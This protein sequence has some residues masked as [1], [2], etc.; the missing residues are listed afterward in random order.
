MDEREYFLGLDLGTASV[1]WAVTDP[2]YRLLRAKGKDMWGVRLCEEADAPE[3]R[4][5]F[6][7]ARRKRNREVLRILELKLLFSEEIEKT[8]PGFF[9]RLEESMLWEEDRSEGNRQPFSLFCDESVPAE[10]EGKN[11]GK[12]YTD[13]DYYKEYPTIFHLRKKLAGGE[14]P[15]DARFLYLALLHMFKHRGHYL[16]SEYT[17]TLSQVLKGHSYVCEAKVASYEKHREDLKKLKRVVRSCGREAYDEMFREMKDGISN[18]SAYIRSVNSDESKSR[19]N[20]LNGKM[21]MESRSKS[22]F[23]KYVAKVISSKKQDPEAQEILKEIKK[24]TFLPKQM[25]AENA[26]IPNH[27][28]AR[29]MKAILENAAK[30]FPFLNETDEAGRTVSERILRLFTFHIPYYVGPLGEEYS[31]KKGYHVWAKRKEKGKIYPWNF[32]EKIDMQETAERYVKRMIRKCSYLSGE[33]VLPE[34]SMIYQKYLVLNELNGIRIKGEKLPVKVKQALYRSLFLSGNSVS[35]KQVEDFLV[36]CH[37]IKEEE[38]NSISGLDSRVKSSLSTVGKFREIFATSVFQPD[39]MEMIERIVFWMTVFGEDT[40][41]IKKLLRQNFG[42]LGDGSLNDSQIKAILGF[43]FSGW[44]NLSAKLLT[45]EGRRKTE[46]RSRGVLMALWETEDTLP[47]LFSERYTYLDILEHFLCEV[48]KPLCEWTIEDLEEIFR[49][50]SYRRMVWQAVR[51]VEEITKVKGYAPKRIFLEMHQV[52]GKKERKRELFE[53]GHGANQMVRFL[54]SALPDTEIVFIRGRFVDGF[55]RKYHFVRVPFVNDFH[56]AEDAYLSI[57]VGN[58]LVWSVGEHDSTI[59]LLRSTL[60]RRTP[61]VTKR[62][63]PGRG[64][65]HNKDTVWSAKLAKEDT[66]LPQKLQDKRMADVTKYGGRTSINNMCYTL[67]EYKVKDKRIRSIEAIPVYLGAA[68]DLTEEQIEAYLLPKIRQEYRKKEVTDFRVCIRVI[69]YRALLKINGYYYY[70]GGKTGYRLSLDNAVQW[71]VDGKHA[72]YIGRIFKAV[73]SN[74]FGEQK[75]N[76]DFILTNEKNRELYLYF[77]E[78][79]KT[80]IYQKRINFVGEFFEKKKEEF[81]ELELAEQ[82]RLL[83][84]VVSGG[85]QSGARKMNL[86]L[87]GGSPN[88]GVM[89]LNKKISEC[90]EALLI[91]QSVTGLFETEVDLLKV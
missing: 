36:R 63:F 45:L 79:M 59:S 17:E 44:G 34:N 56:F 8:D 9:M 71:K 90:S 91:H 76:G 67:V 3:E 46:Q 70:L 64:G 32:E 30:Y 16:S 54:R 28:Y 61:V 68:G 24:E 15:K 53:T 23:Y 31:N 20:D 41:F 65:I 43:K 6:R 75:K 42:D 5:A 50:T 77:L 88:S 69:K 78:K 52:E 1:G 2:H 86:H 81:N 57:A 85:F 73:E 35:R 38:R 13:A 47:E 80:P 26:V 33:N 25:T 4:R 11:D 84:A 40:G 29:E 62:C 89:F 51:I 74:F 21:S 82:C 19:R 66:Y 55:R 18:Y 72:R 14:K 37:V 22:R 58:V 39:N 27:V 48:E 12:K 87:L 83:A 7:K 49:N 60:H 10:N